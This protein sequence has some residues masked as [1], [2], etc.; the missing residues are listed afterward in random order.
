MLKMK[1]FILTLIF[2]SQ[3]LVGQT[4]YSKFVNSDQLNKKQKIETGNRSEEIVFLGEINNKTG[5]P[6]YYVIS[7]F[8]LVKT[9]I[10]VHGHSNILFLDNK[11]KINIFTIHKLYE[12]IK[13]KRG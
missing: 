11:L 3:L 6:I 10:S 7:I 13:I 9:E 5:Q 1:V 12:F 4:D 8:Q 2:Y